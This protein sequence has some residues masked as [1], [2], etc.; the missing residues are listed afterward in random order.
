MEAS[1]GIF[2]N[3]DIFLTLFLHIIQGQ[4][5][6]AQ[7][8]GN[9]LGQK[10]SKLQK[11]FENTFQNCKHF[12]QYKGIAQCFLAQNSEQN[13]KIK[14]LKKGAYFST[15]SLHNAHTIFPQFNTNTYLHTFPLYV[16][17]GLMRINLQY[18]LG[19]QQ[20]ITVET[21]E[22]GTPLQRHRDC[23]GFGAARKC[24]LFAGETANL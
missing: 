21:V 3:F 11:Y 22:L 9:N 24:A 17:G 1:W 6:I 12:V 10:I 4:T 15:K 16:M 23:R 2:T 7:L 13:Y 19:S 5:H 18:L 14:Q 8:E 20:Q